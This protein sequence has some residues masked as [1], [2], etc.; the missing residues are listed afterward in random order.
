MNGKTMSSSIRVV[1]DLSKPIAAPIVTAAAAAKTPPE[2]API[3]QAARKGPIVRPIAELLGGDTKPIASSIHAKSEVGVGSGIFIIAGDKRHLHHPR[4][5][6][7]SS[8]STDRD[9]TTTIESRIQQLKA[10]RR[11]IDQ[12]LAELQ[13]RREDRDVRAVADAML[14]CSMARSRRPNLP[15]ARPITDSTPSARLNFF[16]EETTSA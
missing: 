2:P 16:D 13:G 11:R 3:K 14:E 7:I 1:H 6:H 4:R 15:V 9:T 10:E 8:E 12:E 5:R